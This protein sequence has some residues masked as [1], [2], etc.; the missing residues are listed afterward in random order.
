MNVGVGIAGIRERVRQLNGRFEIESSSQGTTVRVSFDLK[1][2]PS[3]SG[4][5]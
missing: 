1:Q 5:R 2:V 4:R 3:P